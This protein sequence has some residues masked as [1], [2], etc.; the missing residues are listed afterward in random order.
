MNTIQNP[1]QKVVITFDGNQTLA[2]IYENNKVIAKGIATCS[3]EDEFDLKAGS[4]LAM[5][6]ALEDMK[7]KQEW[8][9]VDRKPRVGDYIRITH[10]WFSFNKVEDILKVSEDI[11]N[12]VGVRAT[13]HPQRKNSACKF[14]LDNVWHYPRFAYEVVEL[15]PK[16]PEFRKIT[17]L[18]KAGDYV[19]L[20]H[21]PYTFDKCGDMLKLNEVITCDGH[22]VGFDIRH[23]DH[24]DAI[25]H[26]KRRDVYHHSG[27]TWHYNWMFATYEFYEKV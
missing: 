14:G 12:A 8:V 18:P 3:P 27:Y 22:V 20:I 24:P 2:R 7:S 6:R 17:R 21:S 10:K 4:E 16:K 19:K 1:N 15:A 23:V 9:V 26:C 25:A 13:N 5:T 11:K